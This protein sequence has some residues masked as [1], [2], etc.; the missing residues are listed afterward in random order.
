MSKEKVFKIE[1]RREKKRVK[2][3]KNE[4]YKKDG[5]K[6]KCGENKEGKNQVEKSEEKIQR[7]RQ[8]N[9]K[10]MKDE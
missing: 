7:E 1:R 6:E 10:K 5:K 4:D 9:F 8:I 2:A 3:S